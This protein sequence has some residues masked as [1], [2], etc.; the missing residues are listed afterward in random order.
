LHRE[1]VDEPLDPQAFDES[2]NEVI[3]AY[4]NA[5]LIEADTR[6]GRKPVGAVMGLSNGVFTTLHEATW[7]SWASDRNKVEATVSFF[8]KIRNEVLVLFHC[9]QKEKRFFEY[10]AKH[11]V[12]RRVGNIHDLYENEPAVLFQIRSK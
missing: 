10:V 1:T 5:W 12:L 9:R 6:Y 8:N 2:F 3:S 7:F 4:D 11:N